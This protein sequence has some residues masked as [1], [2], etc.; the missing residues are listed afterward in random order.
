[1]PPGPLHVILPQSRLA[2]SERH[3]LRVVLHFR[4]HQ[5]LGLCRRLLGSVSLVLVAKLNDDG[6]GGRS[7]TVL[8][9]ATWRKTCTDYFRR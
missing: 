2:L 5:L 7:L 6:S 3:M 4:K 9:G 8:S 1:M